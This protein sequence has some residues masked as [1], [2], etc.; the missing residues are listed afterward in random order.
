MGEIS[1]EYEYFKGGLRPPPKNYMHSQD[2]V[3]SFVKKNCTSTLLLFI[4]LLNFTLK[5]F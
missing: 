2:W 3:C 5:Y 4:N 1:L